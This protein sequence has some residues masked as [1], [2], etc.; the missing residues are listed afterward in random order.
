MKDILMFDVSFEV[1]WNHNWGDSNDWGS[2]VLCLH[3]I[4]VIGAV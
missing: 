1:P 3:R 2:D 4:V